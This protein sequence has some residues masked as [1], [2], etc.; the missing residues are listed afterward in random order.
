[1]FYLLSIFF[2]ST[3][4]GKVRSDLLIL[5]QLFVVLYVT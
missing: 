5:Q 4:V 2:T 3:G 1:M